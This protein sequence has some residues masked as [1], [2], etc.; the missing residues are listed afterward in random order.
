MWRTTTVTL[1]A[2]VLLALTA[3]VALAATIDP[4]DCSTISPPG[5]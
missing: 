4:I 1:V 3:G 5:R 2:A